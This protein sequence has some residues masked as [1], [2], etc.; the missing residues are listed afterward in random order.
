MIN[1]VVLQNFYTPYTYI[2]AFAHI[3]TCGYWMPCYIKSFK[4][5]FEYLFYN[6]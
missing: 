5:L 6:T 2:V 3:L 4:F 1:E